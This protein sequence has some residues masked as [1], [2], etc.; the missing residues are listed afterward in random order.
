LDGGGGGEGKS[1]DEESHRFSVFTSA[2]IVFDSSFLN[3][4]LNDLGRD[5]KTTVSDN[6]VRCQWY[7]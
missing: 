7:D 6:S 5:Q 2:G 1:S 4:R 3:A